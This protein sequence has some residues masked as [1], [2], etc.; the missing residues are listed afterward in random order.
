MLKGT[1]ELESLLALM[2]KLEQ[3]NINP[4]K[5]GQN[6]MASNSIKPSSIK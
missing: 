3:A 4:P 2:K 5:E 6:K 1:E